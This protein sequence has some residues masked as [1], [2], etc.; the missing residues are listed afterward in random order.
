MASAPAASVAV[1]LDKPSL[2]PGT[3]YRLALFTKDKSKSRLDVVLTGS[4][5]EAKVSLIDVGSNCRRVWSSHAGAAHDAADNQID[6]Y[7]LSVSDVGD[8]SSLRLE[9]DLESAKRLGGIGVDD[10]NFNYVQVLRASG[11]RVLLFTN[12]PPQKSLGKDNRSVQ[13]NAGQLPPGTVAAVALPTVMQAP[14]SP[15]A[16]GGG[17]ASANVGSAPISTDAASTPTT[18]I[19]GVRT[20][21]E[22]GAGTDGRVSIKFHGG[23]GGQQVETPIFELDQLKIQSEDFHRDSFEGGDNPN[24][25]K[26]VIWR[27]EGKFFETSQES[28]FRIVIPLPDNFGMIS[29]VTVYHDPPRN[30]VGFEDVW[31]PKFVSVN[32]YGGDPESSVTRYF[33]FPENTKM[34]SKLMSFHI[35]DFKD[36][37]KKRGDGLATKALKQTVNIVSVAVQSVVPA[38]LVRPKKNWEEKSKEY[39][40]E[41]KTGSKMGAGTDCDVEVVLCGNVREYTAVLKEHPLNPARLEAEEPGKDLFEQHNLDRFIISIPAA[42]AV[43]DQITKIKVRLLNQKPDWDKSQGAMSSGKEA[44][45]TMMAVVTRDEWKPA[46][47]RIVDYEKPEGQNEFY[48]DLSSVVFTRDGKH[49]EIT[50]SIP[51]EVVPDVTRIQTEEHDFVHIHDTNDPGVEKPEPQG[52]FGFGKKKEEAD[53]KD[54]A[55]KQSKEQDEGSTKLPAKVGE[56]E[57]AKPRRQ[58][59]IDKVGSAAKGLVGAKDKDAD[60]KDASNVAE[61]EPEKGLGDEDDAD[62]DS[63]EQAAPKEILKIPSQ[64]EKKT[65]EKGPYRVYVQIS[66]GRDLVGKKENLMAEPVFQ[67]SACGQKELSRNKKKKCRSLF[68]NQLFIFDFEQKELFDMDLA[69][70]QISYL[71]GGSLFS[72]LLG[73]YE[74]DMSI[75][76]HQDKHEIANVWVALLDSSGESLDIKG[77]VKL[78]IAVVGENDELPVH[79]D[80]DEDEE[81]GMD[82]TQCLMPPNMETKKNSLT[83]VCLKGQGF[84]QLSTSN[85]EFFA[86]AAFGAKRA[87]TV[88]DRNKLS[89]EWNEALR[90]PFVTPTMS[91]DISISFKNSRKGGK[92]QTCGTLHVSLKDVFATFSPDGNLIK[93]SKYYKPKWFN[94]YGTPLEIQRE[95]KFELGPLQS[96]FAK[97]INQSNKGLTVGSSF[98][99]RVLLAIEAREDSTAF[100]SVKGQII[101]SLHKQLIVPTPPQK[102]LLL[103]TYYKCRIV[104]HEGCQF[105]SD[106]VV[107]KAMFGSKTRQT[108]IC[109]KN[110]DT[111]SFD[112]Y[113]QPN[114][115][116][117]ECCFPGDL[118]MKGSFTEEDGDGT[119]AFDPVNGL[120]DIIIEIWNKKKTSRLGFARVPAAEC[121]GTN[122]PAQ[123]ISLTKCPFS[124]LSGFPGFLLASINV[125]QSGKFQGDLAVYKPADVPPRSE[126]WLVSHVYMARSLPSADPNGLSDPYVEIYCGGSK[127]VSS[128]RPETLN[129]VWYENMKTKVI[130]PTNKSI[131]R[132]I[133][134]M[135]WDQDFGSAALP[136]LFSDDFLG[137]VDV[138][139]KDAFGARFTTGDMHNYAEPASWI[140]LTDPVDGSKSGEILLSFQLFPIAED[141]K[142]S[143]AGDMNIVPEFIRDCQLQI[144]ALGCRNLAPFGIRSVNNSLLEFD[145]AASTSTVSAKG[146][147]GKKKKVPKVAQLLRTKRVNVP[148]GSDPNFSHTFNVNVNV[149]LNPLF[150]PII[151]IRCIDSWLF[152]LKTPMVGTGRIVLESL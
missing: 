80:D 7:D 21:N 15:P 3:T 89:P 93:P 91:N 39:V 140:S 96:D 118:H 133:S 42:V 109:T 121:R 46:Y 66:E 123:W 45:G 51:V 137:S 148:S 114:P 97:I 56:A 14:Q 103:P 69:K 70:I 98:C 120:P 73:S 107:V 68:V 150:A 54:E 18:F 2:F 136:S 87:R 88:K 108:D 116:L 26:E 117:A 106:Y 119:G 143:A 110:T 38:V 128:V 65:I 20:K 81:A 112:F 6:V 30:K 124:T 71:D 4:T 122:K 135:V 19:V 22:L 104:L 100:R 127:A 10:Y 62:P 102:P 53:K 50:K 44:F 139:W 11:M 86:E 79:N 49:K 78:S 16:A 63:P 138:S 77:F 28:L 9:W 12:P 129:P 13:M 36:E 94:I 43:G 75:I 101:A 142:A 41:V 47:I 149:P 132:P 82:M 152:G 35:K 32:Q 151:T 74:F 64:E 29:A 55:D 113:R 131:R 27:K 25:E 40:I 72:T 67:V 95:T 83:I 33:N 85:M 76:Y 1:G 115:K 126:Y 59:V 61:E 8:L 147:K 125:E 60:A 31:V 37:K 52:F 144:T 111:G 141:G 17:A 48:F 58:S 84:P 90:L 146:P 57:A 145:L 24:P 5:G 34:N 92:N 99:G 130:L 134:V 105:K 23:Q